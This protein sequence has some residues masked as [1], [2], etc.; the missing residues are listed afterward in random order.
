[1]HLGYYVTLAAMLVANVLILRLIWRFLP[2]STGG[3]VIV[4]GQQIFLGLSLVLLELMAYMFSA[5]E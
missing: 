2:I 5:M 1:M 3:P 4:L